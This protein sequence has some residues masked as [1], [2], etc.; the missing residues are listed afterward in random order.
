MNLADLTSE[1]IQVFL[2]IFA[3]ITAMIA[4]LPILGAASVPTQLKAGM[5]FLL[6][7]MIFPLVEIDPQSTSQATLSLFFIHMIKEVMVGIIIGFAAGFLFT[8]VEFAGHLIDTQM[9]F[10]MVQLINPFTDSTVSTTG[11]FHILIFSLIFLLLNGHYFLI[12]AIQESFELI[13]L[14][15][16][17]FAPDRMALFFTNMVGNIFILGI[18]LAAPVFSVLVLSELALGIVARTVP[19][20]NIFFVGMPMKIGVGIATT[21]I[22]LPVVAK[23][24]WSATQGLFEDIWKL[25]YMMA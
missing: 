5:S 11:Q 19:Q 6:A 1:Q 9:G 24:F 16:M 8:A 12:L 4:L 2:L 13:P 15:G 21:V 25:L 17:Q 10:A 23:L 22:V 20:M 7:I 3:R 18:K 14:F